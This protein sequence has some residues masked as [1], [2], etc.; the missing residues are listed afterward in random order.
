MFASSPGLKSME[1][2]SDC[3]DAYRT[4]CI[5]RVKLQ[6]NQLSSHYVQAVFEHS[7]AKDS[8]AK[9]SSNTWATGFRAGYSTIH[10][11]LVATRRQKKANKYSIPLCFAFIDYQKAFDSIFLTTLPRTIEPGHWWGIM[12]IL[13]NLY[14]EAKSVLL[15]HKDSEKFKLYRKKHLCQT[16]YLRYAIINKINLEA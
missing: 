14:R 11:L 12:N 5:G 15:L 9:F 4:K 8:Y 7:Y 3:L 10:H 16:P 6:N 13:L 1:G 2:C